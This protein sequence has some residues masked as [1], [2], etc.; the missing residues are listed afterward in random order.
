MNILKISYLAIALCSTGLTFTACSDRTYEKTIDE[1]TLTWSQIDPSVR[2]FS[3]R[4]MA[5]LME[6]M[7]EPAMQEE[8]AQNPILAI[9]TMLEKA[10]EADYS[11]LSGEYE[12]YNDAMKP[13]IR[14]MLADIKELP[15][16]PTPK[17]IDELESFQQKITDSMLDIRKKYQDDIDEINARCPNAAILFDSALGEETLLL[18][19]MK[20]EIALERM[21]MKEVMATQDPQ[22]AIKNVASQLR[23]LAEEQK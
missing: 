17:S 23:E 7:A 9:T 20:K 2:K 19:L 16:I 6:L 11:D 4:T 10:I 1:N 12:D 21:T 18:K 8:M 14:K 22:Q 5:D 15:A 3:L 13:I